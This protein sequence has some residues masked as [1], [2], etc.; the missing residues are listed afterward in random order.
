MK[1]KNMSFR[2]KMTVSFLFLTIISQVVMSL[3]SYIQMKRF[4]NFSNRSVEEIS[5]YALDRSEI[6][7]KEQSE[8]YM[9][10]LADGF[11][12]SSDAVFDE[13]KDQILGASLAMTESYET[14]KD[15]SDNFL[16]QDFKKKT[17]SR[18][19][20]EFV[21]YAA[22]YLSR[23]KDDSSDLVYDSD[24]YSLPQ[25]I[26]MEMQSIKDA[27]Y[28]MK[29]MYVYNLALDSLYVGT[30]S[31]ILG[32]YSTRQIKNFF[33]PRTRKWYTDAVSKLES[34][35]EDV[36]WQESYV[37]ASTG[38][39][40]ITCSK[41]FKDKDGKIAGVVA[42]DIYLESVEENI[43]NVSLGKSGYAFLIDNQGDIV[44]SPSSK[45]ERQNILEQ[46]IDDS[47]R[48]A[49]NRMRNME[50]GAEQVKIDGADYYL[51]F[52]PMETVGWSLG[53][54]AHVSEIVEPIT[55]TKTKIDSDMDA[56]SSQVEGMLS[57][58]LMQFV[59]IMTVSSAGVFVVAFMLSEKI[60]APIVRLAERVSSM[61]KDG[62]PEPIEVESNDEIG[63]FSQAFNDMTD[64]IK[65]Y[66]S[67][68]AVTISE[69]QKIH[70]ELNVAK[71]IQAGMLPSIFPAFPCRTDFDIYAT[72]NPAKEV[73]GDFYDF[74][75]IDN[76]HLAMTIADV[77]GKGVAA[78]LFM[79]IAKTLLKNEAQSG[80]SVDEVL[81]AVNKKLCEN[82]DQGMFVTAF[83]CVFNIRT[84]ELKFSN[85]G[86]NHPL[87][88]RKKYDKFEWLKANRGFVLAGL[89]SVRYKLESTY[90][91]EGDMLYLYTDGV[92][93]AVNNEN[94]LF[95]DQR[96]IDA[97][98]DPRV[99]SFSLKEILQYVRKEIDT[100]ANGANQADDI[101]MLIFKNQSIDVDDD[102]Y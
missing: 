27:S 68:L 99:K 45:G 88:Y 22:D 39:V 98:N 62:L 37:A 101:T 93:E 16:T 20:V 46:D 30:Q 34:G 80:S 58:I 52:A 81:T 7:L 53:V 15:V 102:K 51:A 75:F 73:G 66:V 79:V 6:A 31:G 28:V 83:I 41:A 11:S 25:N 50:S 76:D 33:D 49:V 48:D 95:S 4:G 38:E 97:M 1:F 26:L 17:E 9:T 87:I 54:T 84:G 43:L 61:G 85:A 56:V 44:V 40:A 32:R 55:Q 12:S 14:S 5:D 59:V 67:E 94:K 24:N 92:T 100:F 72:M 78:A 63:K 57:E 3:I 70:S 96:L 13:I 90:L 35:N 36:V 64:S 86:H 69:K 74:F 19:N 42:A 21:A 47:Y 91:D 2:K 77:S 89:E 10:K 23:S 65:Q 29:P 71:K 82:N 8:A 60:S 18:E